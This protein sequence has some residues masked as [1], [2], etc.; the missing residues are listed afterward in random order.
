MVYIKAV[1]NLR[2]IILVILGVV[3]SVSAQASVKYKFVVTSGPSTTSHKPCMAELVL[4]DSA[5]AAGEA[6][7]DDIESLRIVKRNGVREQLNLILETVA[8]CPGLL[9]RKR[10]T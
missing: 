9:R 8:L 1:F 10:V 5:V 7:K 4:S 6:M 3:F 2:V